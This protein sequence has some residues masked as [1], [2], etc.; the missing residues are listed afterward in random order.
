MSRLG[1]GIWLGE[2]E[3]KRLNAGLTG[4][5]NDGGVRERGFEWASA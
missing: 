2:G 1:G 4:R 5:G 3:G